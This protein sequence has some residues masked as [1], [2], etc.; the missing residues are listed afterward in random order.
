[1][2]V[3]KLFV[4]IKDQTLAAEFPA[5]RPVDVNTETAR[6]NREMSS[7][8]IRAEIN[9]FINSLDDAPTFRLVSPRYLKW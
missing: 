6:A 9:E 8:F 4:L 2:G 5:E 1:M 3:V 7:F